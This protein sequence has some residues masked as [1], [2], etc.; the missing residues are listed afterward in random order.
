MLT[1]KAI[2]T[3]TTQQLCKN[4]HTHFHVQ[5][6]A[7]MLNA[8]LLKLFQLFLIHQY[9]PHIPQLIFLLSFSYHYNFHSLNIL[10]HHMIYRI[11]IHNY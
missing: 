6:G 11:Y 7:T 2:T 1:I 9:F 4:M 10:Q 5:M 8:I 3:K